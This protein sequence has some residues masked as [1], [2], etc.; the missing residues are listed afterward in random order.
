VSAASSWPARLAR[1][2]VHDPPRILVAEDDREMLEILVQVLS[3]DGYDVQ[4]AH[5][6]GR[7]LVQLAK[8]PKCSYQN[9]DLIISDICMPICSGMQILETLRVARCAVPIILMTGFADAHT[10]M[11]ADS[12]GA[13]LFAKPFGLHDLLTTV[14]ELL[15]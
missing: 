3:A 12:L 7:M 1:R 15:A 5:D 11:R 4:G 10:K 9:V 13:V 6:G 8:G 14:A 2:P